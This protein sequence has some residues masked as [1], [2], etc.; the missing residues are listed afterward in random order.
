VAIVLRVSVARL[1]GHRP[2]LRGVEPVTRLLHRAGMP[3]AV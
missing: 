2:C 1:K 3:A